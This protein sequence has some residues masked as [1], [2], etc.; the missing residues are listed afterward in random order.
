[1][2]PRK[3]QAASGRNI[4]RVQ[5]LQ[6][7]LVFRQ[8]PLDQYPGLVEF[9]LCRGHLY[10]LAQVR[11]CHC[12]HIGAAGFQRVRGL[13]DALGV[14]GL[15]R[16]PDRVGERERAR[17]IQAEHLGKQVRAARPVQ[18]ADTS[19]RLPVEHDSNT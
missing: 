17:G 15:R 19:Q 12:T 7:F 4:L 16:R 8:Q 10:L 2:Q 18:C 3:R 14:V 13:A 11:E 9:A 5:G 6:H 1:M